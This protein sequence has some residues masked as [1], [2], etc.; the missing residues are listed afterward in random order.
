MKI[1]EVVKSGTGFRLSQTPL[2]SVKKCK[3]KNK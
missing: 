2:F 3:L 1:V